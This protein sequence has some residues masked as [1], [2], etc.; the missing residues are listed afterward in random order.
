MLIFNKLSGAKKMLEGIRVIELEGIGPGPFAGMT[1]AD[2]GADVVKVHRPSPTQED[3][4][5]TLSLLDRGKRSVILNLK[6]QKDKYTLKSL[7]KSADV[8]IEGLRP[9]VMESLGLDE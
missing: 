6:D 2:L 5:E 3:K 8:L 9:G 7:I 1:L 4:K